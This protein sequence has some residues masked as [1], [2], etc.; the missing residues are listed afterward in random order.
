MSLSQRSLHA[1]HLWT[2]ATAEGTDGA[3]L[4]GQRVISKGGRPRTLRIWIGI[5]CIVQ[6]IGG[7]GTK[8]GGSYLTS[9]KCSDFWTHLP[10]PIIVQG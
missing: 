10:F 8:H 5:T 2:A 4:G 1:R 9:A 3:G 7:G 6:G